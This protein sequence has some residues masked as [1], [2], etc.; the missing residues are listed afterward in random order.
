MELH[1]LVIANTNQY[2]A[3]VSTLSITFQFLFM[4][5]FNYPYAL[6]IGVFVFIG[7]YMGIRQVNKVIKKTGK[8]SVIV[9]ALAFVLFMSLI[10]I[11]LKYLI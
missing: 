4:G 7:S 11:P 9:F 1:P 8:Q 6:Y 10:T 3:L 5:V 2:L